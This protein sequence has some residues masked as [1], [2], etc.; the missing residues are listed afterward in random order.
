MISTTFGSTPRASVS[1]MRTPEFRKASSRRRCSSVAKSNSVLVKVSLRGQEG[2]LRA[3]LARL[4]RR[5]PPARSPSGSPWRKRMKY[6]L[7][8]RQ[9]RRSSCSDKRVDHRRAD[10]VQA[11]RDL[12]GV[13][14]EFSAGMELGHDDLGRRDAL[15]LVDVDR[16][17]AAVVAHR[18][19]AVAVQ[20]HLDAVAIAGQRLVDRVVDDL[21]DHVV[22]AGAVVGVADIHARPLA[23]GVEAAQHLDRIGAVGRR[24][25]AVAGSSAVRSSVSSLM[26]CRL[27]GRDG[28]V[29]RDRAVAS[30]A[31]PAPGR[32]AA[33]TARR[34]CRSSRLCAPSATT[35][36]NSAARRSA[37]RWAATSSSSSSGAP[38]ARQGRQARMGQHDRD[39]QRLLLAGRALG[40]RQ[41]EI[42]MAHREVAAMRP[43]GCACRSRRRASGWP[44]SAARSRSSA[45]SAAIVAEPAVDLA[46]Q[47]SAARGKGPTPRR[48]AASRRWHSVGARGGQRHAVARHGVLQRGEPVRIA[49]ALAQQARRARAAHCS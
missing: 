38:A 18:D 22:Q 23:H 11:A 37:S 32:R 5:R 44:P 41:V 30:R 19:R 40:R 47:A 9:M 31:E 29:G 27:S 8:S 20:H 17:A 45:S 2:H 12:V 39:Q 26:S 7:P 49:A 14:V 24:D 15:F 4:A 10:A 46:G 34:R 43:D 16:H 1:T 3:V 33:R 42:E 21:V 25:G 48:A 13:L 36:S 28:Q 35:S 6:S